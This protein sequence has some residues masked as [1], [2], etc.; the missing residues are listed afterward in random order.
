MIS[1]SIYIQFP[2]VCP[3]PR[4]SPHWGTRYCLPAIFA[5]I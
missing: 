1:S 2:V 5:Q 4:H 3:Q